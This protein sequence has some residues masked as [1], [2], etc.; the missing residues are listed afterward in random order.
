MVDIRTQIES[1]MQKAS[2]KIDEHIIN[3][4]DAF[5]AEM[6]KNIIP[7]QRAFK[8]LTGNTITSFAYGVYLDKQM[9]KVGYFNGND[10][11]RGKLTKDE[12]FG[13][14]DYDG[15]PRKFTGV[16]QTDGGSG[17][18]TSLSFLN[19]YS[20]HGKYAIVFTTGTEYSS[21]LETKLHLNVLT[22]ARIS[23]I[24]AFVNSFKPIK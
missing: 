12:Y 24:A 9:V 3:Q 18:S 15:T 6:V 19:S 13:G 20:P 16:I 14:I 4:M 22:D 11:I 21:Y 8:N 1:L 23:S 7:I 5:G 2:P 17:K 10:P